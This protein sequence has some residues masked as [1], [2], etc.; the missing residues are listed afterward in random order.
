MEERQA[1]RVRIVK[2][3]VEALLGKIGYLFDYPESDSQT[4]AHIITIDGEEVRR[5]FVDD[6]YEYVVEEL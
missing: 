2:G 3:P 1:I 5:L 6:G 4:K